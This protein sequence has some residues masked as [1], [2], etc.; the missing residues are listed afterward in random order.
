ML[1]RANLLR[2]RGRWTDAADVC[3]EVLRKEPS[4]PTGH[5]LLGDIYQDQ[6]RPEEAIYWY[7]HALELNPGSEADRAKLA[8]AQETL[9]ARQQRAEWEAVIEGRAQPISTSLLVRESLQ[10]VGALA[11]AAVCAIILVMAII[12]SVQ[13]RPVTAGA[14]DPGAAPGVRA[15]RAVPSSDTSVEQTLLSELRSLSPGG[16]ARLARLEV[17]PVTATIR[18]RAYLPADPRER[19]SAGFRGAVMRD[20]YRLARALKGV[21]ASQ[22]LGFNLTGIE[23]EI[24]GPGRGAD[25]RPALIFLGTLSPEHLVA[26]PESATLQELESFYTGVHWAVE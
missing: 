16:K 21:A 8:R 1:T 5:S 22:S 19:S 7:Q 24:I 12:V 26:D 14:D 20:G 17:D 11:G 23:V 13:E 3:V 10:R 25:S 9:E 15:P 2:M 18:L 6:G 4:N